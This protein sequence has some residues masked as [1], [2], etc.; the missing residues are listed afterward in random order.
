LI[1]YLYP[2]NLRAEA[3]MWL[4]SMRDFTVAA[5][6][7][8]VSALVF[9]TA[10]S[11]LPLAVTGVYAF[12]TIRFEEVCVLDFLGWAARFFISEQQF[13]L[14]KEIPHAEKKKQK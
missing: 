13:F 2:Q 1:Q 9:S 4:W 7:A 11:P 12:L 10:K 8:L 14:W 6:C 3:G 5:I